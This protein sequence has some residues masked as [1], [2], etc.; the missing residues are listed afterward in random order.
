MR[1]RACVWNLELGA[2]RKEPTA[3][4]QEPGASR[5]PSASRPPVLSS[6]H[7]SVVSHQPVAIHKSSAS[8][9]PLAL[10]HLAASR[11]PPVASHQGQPSTSG[12][13]RRVVGQRPAASQRPATSGQHCQR[14]SIRRQEGQGVE[15]V[16][17]CFFSCF[18]LLFM[19]PLFL[20]VLLNV[21]PQSFSGDVPVIQATFRSTSRLSSQPVNS[22]VNSRIPSRTVNVPVK[23]SNSFF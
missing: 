7:E 14:P 8:H 13:W 17:E 23:Q 12:P 10:C 16:E 15:R 20:F 21:S 22:P 9:L 4:N 1:R 19:F 6:S 2:S 11:Q 5:Q 18:P 3:R